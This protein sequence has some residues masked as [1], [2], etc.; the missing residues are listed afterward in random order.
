[1]KKVAVLYICTGRYSIFWKDFYKS[2]KSKLFANSSLEFFVFTDQ[3]I[4]VST[5]DVHLIYQEKMGWPYDTLMRFHLFSKIK[6]ELKHFDYIFFMNANL[7]VEKEISSSLL[8]DKE[9]LFGVIHPGFYNKDPA[10]FTYERN[11]KSTAYIPQGKGHHYFM[12]GFNGGKSSAF[13]QLIEQLSSNIQMDLDNNIIAIWHDES[14]LNRYFLD[15]QER[16]K[17]VGPE[18]GYPQGWNLPLERK[19]TILDKTKFGGHSFLRNEKQELNLSNRST[20]ISKGGMPK[21][22]LIDKIFRYFRKK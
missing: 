4:D 19:I 2:A 17:I 10:E 13:I 11:S 14:H 16:L 21:Q 8:P 5:N 22:G 9:D 3:D 7:I 15:H 6:D 20:S 12:G 1:M 18:Y